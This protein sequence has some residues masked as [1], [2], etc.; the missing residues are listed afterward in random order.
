LLPAKAFAD[1]PPDTAPG[2]GETTTNALKDAVILIIRH[3]EKPEE[4]TDLSP[5]GRQRADAYVHYFE[6]YNVAAHPLA[7]D[8]LV[9]AADSAGSHRP[10]LTLEPLSKASGLKIDLRFKHKDCAGLARDLRTHFHGKR[11]LVCWHHGTIAELVTA[12]GADAA[13]LLPGGKWPDDEFG[14]VLELRYDH[15]AHLIPGET[16]RLN[17][18]LPLSQTLHTDGI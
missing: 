7:L 18:Q 9:A 1:S 5:A 8:Y 4:G 6:H 17:E 10:R 15:D 14:W 13:K 12:L 16:R 11:I 2:A 3:G